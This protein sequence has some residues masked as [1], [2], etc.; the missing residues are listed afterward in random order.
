MEGTNGSY[1]TDTGLEVANGASFAVIAA[2]DGTHIAVFFDAPLDRS[3]GNARLFVSGDN[4]GGVTFAE[5]GESDETTATYP[6]M[7]FFW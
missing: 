6:N 4:I 7:Y 3:G 1:K 2:P 5:A